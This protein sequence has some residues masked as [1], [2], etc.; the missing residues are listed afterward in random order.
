MS[1]TYK[2]VIEGDRIKWDGPAPELAGPIRVEVSL[3]G[4]PVRRVLQGGDGPGAAAALAAIAAMGGL[5]VED[6]VA[7]QRE[8]RQDRP[9]PGRD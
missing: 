2:A 5:G 3:P 9:L 8:V 1:Q 6:P 4:P 7:W